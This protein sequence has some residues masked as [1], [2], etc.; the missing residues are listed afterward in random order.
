MILNEKYQTYVNFLYNKNC[1]NIKHS[2][3]NFLN[4]LTD[5]IQ[6]HGV[7]TPIPEDW[8]ITKELQTFLQTNY[9]NR[10]IAV[11]EQK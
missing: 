9:N 1:H 11:P 6:K 10:T 5:L 3:S 4:H 7:E 8:N 2:H